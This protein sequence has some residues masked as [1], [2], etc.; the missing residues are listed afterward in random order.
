MNHMCRAHYDRE[1][2]KPECVKIQLQGRTPNRFLLIRLTRPTKT[3]K[4]IIDG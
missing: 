2:T 4:S 1:I 3:A